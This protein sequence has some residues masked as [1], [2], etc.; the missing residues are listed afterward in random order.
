MD[1]GI[2]THPLQFTIRCFMHIMRLS[3]NETLNLLRID[4]TNEHVGVSTFEITH[5]IS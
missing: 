2:S 4:V 1:T 5:S 3:M